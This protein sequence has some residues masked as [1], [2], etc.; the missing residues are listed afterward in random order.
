MRALPI[1]RC[2]GI[3]AIELAIALP[4]ILMVLACLLFFGSLFYKYQVTE[5]AAWNASRYLSSVGRLEMKNPAQIVHH[6]TF[7][8][9]MVDQQLNAISSGAYPPSVT[10]LCGATICDGF[11]LPTTVTVTV[12][13]LATE[14]L[15]GELISPWVEGE[16]VLTSSATL[17]YVGI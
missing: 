15:F 12:R 17:A 4:F 16:F 5:K 11:T 6:T 3:A 14:R 7:A 2:R 10:I 9:Y 8:R 1:Q 13:I